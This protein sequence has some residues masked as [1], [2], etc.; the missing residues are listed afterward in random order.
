VAALQLFANSL[1]PL[2]WLMTEFFSILASAVLKIGLVALVLNE[3]RGFVLAA[4]VLYGMYLAGGSAMALWIGFCSLC[5]I[6]LS[7]VA[8][9]FVAKRFNLIPARA[10]AKN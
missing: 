9:V 3:V 5:G 7:V 8:P 6:A 10:S 2:S 4:P 1:L